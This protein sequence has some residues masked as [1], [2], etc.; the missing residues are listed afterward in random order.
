MDNPFFLNKLSKN[1]R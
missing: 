1:L